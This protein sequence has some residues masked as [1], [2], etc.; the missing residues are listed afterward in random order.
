MK[1][2]ELYTTADIKDIRGILELRAKVTPEMPIIKYKK[3]KELVTVTCGMLWADVCRFG[4]YLSRRYPERS[5]FALLGE[6][7]YLWIITFF[8]IVVADGIVVPFDKDFATADLRALLERCP[9]EALICSDSYKDVAE[10]LRESGAVNEL[11]EMG[12][13][14]E[15][16]ESEATVS[17]E[18]ETDPGAVCAILFTSGTTGDP[19]GVMMSQTNYVWDI[20]KGI[21]SIWL[22]GPNV[23]TLPLHHS[24]AFTINVL[25]AYICGSCAYLS[26]GLRYFQKELKEYSPENLGVVPLYVETIYKNIW[27]TAA[28]RGS[29][30]ALRRL[31]SLSRFLRRIGIDLRRKLFRPVLAE[32]GGNLTN[33]LCG[34]AF[35][36]QKYIDGMADFGISILNG[37]GITECSPIV[38][39]NRFG[40]ERAHSV[41]QPI[42][43]CEVKIED[44]EIC[45]RGE[46]VMLGYYEEEAATA[47]VI[48]NGWFYTGDLGYLDD[49][50]YLYITGRKKNLII[51]SNGENVSPEELELKLMEI[52]NVDEVIVSEENGAITAEIYAEDRR[53]IDEAVDRLNRLLPI[54]K[55]IQNIKYR[56]TAFEK[57]TTRKIKRSYHDR[58]R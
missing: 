17:P 58:E 24:F 4:T 49:D 23:L 10:E 50:G 5:R 39:F 18:R 36:D 28:E 1:D 26:R 12:S 42:E 13:I 52:G 6:N 57:T 51:L 46:N 33:I 3:G 40:E 14:P 9:V 43:G 19:K 31:V 56:E 20:L 38:S 11:I 37:Y 35:L 22:T 21:R 32:L 16:M 34:G 15:I 45:V 44:G 8:A 53:G 2:N 29:E 55:R 41:G 54:Y 30:K 25:G 48:R 47:E 7:S 27:K